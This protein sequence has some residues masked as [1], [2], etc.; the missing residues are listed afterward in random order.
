VPSQPAA[1]NALVPTR[2]AAMARDSTPRRPIVHVV[3]AL[4]ICCRANSDVRFAKFVMLTILGWTVW[5][6]VAIFAI[7]WAHSLRGCAKQGRPVPTVVAVQTVFL[8]VIAV[9]FLFVHYSKL[10][11]LWVVAI[12]WLISFYLILGWRAPIL[13][14]LVLWFGGLFVKIALI[15][16]KHPTR[17]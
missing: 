16:V 3:H 15:G 2:M 7:S 14:P 9:L 11:M 4:S 1:V 8:W 6:L 5:A 17:R 10:H 12:S 13:S